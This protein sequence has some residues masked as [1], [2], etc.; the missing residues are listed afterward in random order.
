MLSYEQTGFNVM[1]YCNILVIKKDKIRFLNV[2]H[3]KHGHVSNLNILIGEGDGKN[4]TPN[5][6]P[7]QNHGSDLK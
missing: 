1:Q 3:E 2:E 4:T 7:S 5:I 6:Q